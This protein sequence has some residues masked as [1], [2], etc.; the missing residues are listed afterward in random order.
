MIASSIAALELIESDR[1]LV[2]KPLEKARLFTERMG[3]EPPQSAIVPLIL[4]EP[5]TAL[6][7]SAALERQ[8]FLVTAIRPPTVP[9][10]TSRLRFTFSAAHADEDTVRL[11]ESLRSA[12][13]GG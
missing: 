1:E 9:E 7:A 3:L 10:G 12:G 5:E 6:R 4:G 8:G 11:S 2:A 13:V